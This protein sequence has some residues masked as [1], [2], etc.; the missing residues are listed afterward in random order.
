MSFP[1]PLKELFEKSKDKRPSVTEYVR[2]LQKN[3]SFR[4]KLIQQEN[5]IRRGFIKLH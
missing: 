3:H 1:K 2:N 4:K 5:S